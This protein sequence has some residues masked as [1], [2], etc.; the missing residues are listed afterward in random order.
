MEIM[1]I[2]IIIIMITITITIITIIIIIIT[3]IIMIIIIIIMIII[4]II[5]II[6]I[7]II[8]IVSTLTCAPATMYLTSSSASTTT[9]FLRTL[10]KGEMVTERISSLTD[11]TLPII[12]FSSPPTICTT[13][14]TTNDNT[15]LFDSSSPT[16]SINQSINHTN[17]KKMRSRKVGNKKHQQ[18]KLHEMINNE[19]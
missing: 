3:I 16:Q 1:M 18:I 6:M 15:E 13:S 2:I 8:I 7:I 4:I 9:S 17:K 10:L 11:V 19:E 12:F 5:M 14:P